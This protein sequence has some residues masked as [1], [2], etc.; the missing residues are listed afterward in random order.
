MSNN[1]QVR[2]DIMSVL[3]DNSKDIPDGVYLELCNKLQEFK[4]KDRVVEID[5]DGLS[6]AD[7]RHR[8]AFL[9][10]QN[11]ELNHQIVRLT[12]AG[13]EANRARLLAREEERRLARVNAEALED[14]RRSNPQH[15]YRPGKYIVN[16]E[17]GRDVLRTGRIGRRLARTQ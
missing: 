9:R 16:P 15:V 5:A 17:T 13:I 2:S 8:T 7:H 14:W 10:R 12:A 6:F 3:D 11:S 1:Q 4:F